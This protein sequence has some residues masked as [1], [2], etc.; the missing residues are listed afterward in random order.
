MTDH[1]D[2]DDDD[3]DH[4]TFPDSL[5]ELPGTYIT[6]P[7]SSFHHDNQV[8]EKPQLLYQ[9]SQRSNETLWNDVKQNPWH[10]LLLYVSNFCLMFAC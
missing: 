4:H 6:N 8:G 2:C 3:W 10:Y 5:Q 1:D 7:D 9:S